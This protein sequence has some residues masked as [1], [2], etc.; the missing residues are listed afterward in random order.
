MAK[1]HPGFTLSDLIRTTAKELKEAQAPEKDAVMQFEGCELELSV[2]AGAEGGAGI[3]FWL[4][5][6]SAKARAET[7]SKIKLSFGPIPGKSTQHSSG[8]NSEDP[9][10]ANKKNNKSSSRRKKE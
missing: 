8:T 4:V 5:E 6:A 3:K 7:I 2:T 10:P 1:P 9:G